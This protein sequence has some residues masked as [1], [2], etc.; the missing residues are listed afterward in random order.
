MASVKIAARVQPV[1]PEAANGVPFRPVEFDKMPLRR[2]SKR[3]ATLIGSPGRCVPAASGNPASAR[4]R[5]RDRPDPDPTRLWRD[6][7]PGV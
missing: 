5:P 3:A 1:L 6:V 4:S 7:V 2:T